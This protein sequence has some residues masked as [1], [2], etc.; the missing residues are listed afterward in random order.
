MASLDLRDLAHQEGSKEDGRWVVT[1]EHH[2]FP[3]TAA[4]ERAVT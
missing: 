1:H 2:S 4:G 3:D